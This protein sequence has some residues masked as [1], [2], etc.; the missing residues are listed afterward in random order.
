MTEEQPHDFYAE[1]MEKN[2]FKDLLRDSQIIEEC[3]IVK[4]RPESVAEIKEDTYSDKPE[5]NR[6]QFLKKFGIIGLGIFGTGALGMGLI[7]INNKPNPEKIARG[8]LDNEAKKF[9]KLIDEYIKE[10]KI[11]TNVKIYYRQF[12]GHNGKKDLVDMGQTTIGQPIKNIEKIVSSTD[13]NLEQL[14]QEARRKSLFECFNAAIKDAATQP[15]I[16]NIILITNYSGALYDEKT[17]KKLDPKCVKC[18][19]TCKKYHDIYSLTSRTIL[20]YK[21]LDSNEDAS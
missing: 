5:T 18:E 4:S 14:S 9:Y 10:N 11:D 12:L 3:R 8:E 20:K 21:L 6:R 1:L 15:E 13:E 19:K 16:K 7:G 2:S 17:D